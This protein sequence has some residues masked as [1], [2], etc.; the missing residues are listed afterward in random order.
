M[1][2]IDADSGRVLGSL[3]W[4]DGNQLF[5]IDWIPRRVAATLPFVMGAAAPPLSLFYAYRPQ[6]VKLPFNEET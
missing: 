6:G 2:A 3:T 1:H 5:A 4:P